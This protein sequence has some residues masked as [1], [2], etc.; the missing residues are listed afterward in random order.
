MLTGNL[1]QLGC[2]F[3]TIPPKCTTFHHEP[4]PDTDSSHLL[5][6]CSKRTSTYFETFFDSLLPSVRKPSDL[7]GPPT[8]THACKIALII[9]EN[10]KIFACGGQNTPKKNRPQA[11]V[12]ASTPSPPKNVDVLFEASLIGKIQFVALNH[13]YTPNIIKINTNHIIM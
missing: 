5:R 11:S 2:T 1:K 7:T 4:K 8:Y 12:N 9:I 6:G 3:P 10:S 13:H